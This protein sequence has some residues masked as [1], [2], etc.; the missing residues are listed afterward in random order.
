MDASSFQ[1]LAHAGLHHHSFMGS[2]HVMRDTDCWSDHRHVCCV[3]AGHFET[4]LNQ[5][6]L[7]DDTVLN[8]IPQLEEVWTNIRLQKKRNQTP[9]F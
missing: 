6:S 4:V 5:S 3:V 7:F 2:S 1:T 8:E 9:L